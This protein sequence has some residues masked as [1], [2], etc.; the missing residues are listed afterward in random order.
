M[1]I[2]VV[3]GAPRRTGYT[4]EIVDLFCAGARAAGAEVEVVDLAARDVRP[5][6]GC[7]KCWRST[8]PG[9]CVQ[10]DDMHDLIERFYGSQ[11]LVLATPLYYYSFSAL[12]KAF[13]ERMLPTT[14]PGIDH[15]PRLGTGRNLM[16][17]PDRGPEGAVLIAVGAHRN[18]RNMDGLVATFELICE[19]LDVEPVGKLLRPESYFLDFAPGKPI[20]QRKIRAAFE[21]AGRELVTA[22]RVSP[23]IEAEAALPLADD[24]GSFAERTDV[25]WQIAAELGVHGNDRERVRQVAAEDLQILI[26]ELAACLDPAVAGDLRVVIMIGIDDDPERGWHLSIAAGRCTA[27][28][29]PHASPDLTL[30][31]QR[32]TLV[33]MIFGRLDVRAAVSDGT[34]RTAG[35]L[36]LL[37]R[38]GRLFPPPSR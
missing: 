18:P 15:G 13:I 8:S 22:G 16:R 20:T 14:K 27:L 10:D 6:T 28:R 25:Y 23:A 19:G 21:S 31:L 5:C 17:H 1:D 35:S 3:N 24:D 2:L 12:L 36:G 30:Q 38:M 7:Y 34:I 37:A 11:Q 33:D 32:Q 4:R 26:P 9:R 29:G